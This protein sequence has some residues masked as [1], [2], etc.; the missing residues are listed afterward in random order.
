[1][2]AQ[3]VYFFTSAVSLGAP[4]NKVSFVVPT[5]NFGDIFAGYIA[6]QMGLPIHRLIIATNEN[7]ILHRTLLTGEYVRENLMLTCSPSMDI[8]ISSNFERLLFELEEKN[9]SK[10]DEKMQNLNNFGRFSLS[11]KAF[12]SL[13]ENFS[14]G[15][16][17][18]EET[19]MTIKR[20]KHNYGEIVC[21]HTAVALKVAESYDDGHTFPVIS[22]ATAHP[23]KFPEA[24]E[25]ATGNPPDLPARYS[26]LFKRQER[27]VNVKN[28]VVD[29]QKIIKDR[30]FK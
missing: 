14:S 6:K 11:S 1:M 5:G 21:P 15:K 12:L 27:V 20:V 2:L 30:I 17:S 10:I 22:L 16:V 3:T 26:D 29:V 9:G 24:V 13:K 18:N 8:Q 19:L 7:D 28:S 4:Q 23:S 25:I